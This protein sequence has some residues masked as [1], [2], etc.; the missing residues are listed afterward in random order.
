MLVGSNQKLSKLHTREL[1]P[2]INNFQLEHV[3][4][5]ELLGVHLYIM[6]EACHLQNMSNCV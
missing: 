5:D 6:I 4:N 2:S 1:D 3:E